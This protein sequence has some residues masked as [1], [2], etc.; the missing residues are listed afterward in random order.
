MACTETLANPAPEYELFS[1]GP[2]GH[3]VRVG[4]STPSG[5]HARFGPSWRNSDF[6]PPRFHD[7]IADTWAVPFQKIRY[8]G[9]AMT[10]QAQLSLALNW[11][12]NKEIK[13][14]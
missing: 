2:K 8:R 7:S 10:W 6:G 1:A 5:R 14:D 9:E 12:T 3:A 11:V 13:G 4:R